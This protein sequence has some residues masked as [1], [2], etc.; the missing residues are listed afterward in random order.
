MITGIIGDEQRYGCCFLGKLEHCGFGK[1]VILTEDSGKMGKFEGE[2]AWFAD[3][4]IVVI[5]L[6]ARCFVTDP[7]IP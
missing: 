6:G 5:R 7:L 2:G 4:F 1:D 3:R